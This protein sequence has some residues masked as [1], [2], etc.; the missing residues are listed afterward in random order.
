MSDA[1]DDTEPNDDAVFTEKEIGQK[2]TEEWRGV[3][4]LIEFVVILTR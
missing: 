1:L 2:S 4:P 3:D